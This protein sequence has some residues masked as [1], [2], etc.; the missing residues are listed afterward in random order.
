MAEALINLVADAVASREPRTVRAAVIAKAIR[1]QTSARWV[2]IYTVTVDQVVNE[3]WSGPAAPAH[4][5]FRID[6]GLTAHA[7]SAQAVAVSNNVG[8][9]PRYL[10]NQS[11]TG[12]ELIVPVV[13]D[14]RTLGTLD[15]EESV[16]GAFDGRTINL[17]EEIAAE[18]T[19]LWT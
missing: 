18:L 15:V 16:S 17:Y 4:P 9:D 5:I 6:Q 11:D 13:H 10:T 3:A 1:D 7:I 19:G 2:G 14:D 8:T 12:S